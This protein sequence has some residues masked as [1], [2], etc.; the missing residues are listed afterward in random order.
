MRLFEGDKI[1]FVDS[2][3]DASRM[4]IPAWVMALFLAGFVS[5]CS[6]FGGRA[7]DE[8]QSSIVYEDGAMQIRQY[9]GFAVA[10]TRVSGSYENASSEGF[11]RLFN[12]IAGRNQSAEKIEMTAPVL[13]EPDLTIAT[14]AT[15][16]PS[17]SE[18]GSPVRFDARMQTWKVAFI[19]P[20][21]FAVENSP[22]PADARVSLRD[23]PPRQVAVISFSGWLRGNVAETKRQ[24]LAEWLESQGMNHEGDWR[25]A[26]YSPPWTMPMLRRNEV[27]VTLK[28]EG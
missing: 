9:E 3:Q 27:M 23:V 12:Y 25:V 8:P 20:D 5:A 13:V 6:V 15:V 26:G 16:A 22:R 24:E 18:D 1:V 21:G 19:L 17:S 28:S 14:L 10:E 7:A 11:S 2:N 4:K